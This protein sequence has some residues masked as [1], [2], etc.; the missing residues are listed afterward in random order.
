MRTN[1]ISTV[2]Y[3]PGQPPSNVNELASFLQTELDNIRYAINTLAV[4]HLDITYVEPT[5]P[6]DGDIRFADGT[7][8][9]P[10]G[11]GKG[12]YGYYNAAW[13]LLG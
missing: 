3:T 6:R 12:F 7:S 11:A 2:Q 5:K 8:F 13:H 1:S 10:T 9:N 4:G